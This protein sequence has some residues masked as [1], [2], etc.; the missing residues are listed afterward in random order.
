MPKNNYLSFAKEIALHCDS[1]I[2]RLQ[3]LIESNE[4]PTLLPLFEDLIGTYKTI[5][6]KIK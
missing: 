3:N 1:E 2:I 5:K 4:Y 6:A